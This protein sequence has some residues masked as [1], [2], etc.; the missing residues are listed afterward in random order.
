MRRAGC[1]MST[2][3]RW[4]PSMQCHLG[5]CRSF[6]RDFPLEPF[7]RSLAGEHAYQHAQRFVAAIARRSLPCSVSNSPVSFPSRPDHNATSPPDVDLCI[8]TQR[9]EPTG[10]HHVVAGS[11]GAASARSSP[12]AR[13]GR[14]EAE[15]L[16]GAEDRRTIRARDGRKER[17]RGRSARRPTR[18]TRRASWKTGRR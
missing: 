2:G 3:P 4:R 18:R 10:G 7:T 17:L 6:R 16:D 14:S 9:R 1:P 5:W 8:R 12:P 15:W 13:E 11:R